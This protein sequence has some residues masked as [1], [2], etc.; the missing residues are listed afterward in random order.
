MSVVVA[1]LVLVWPAVCPCLGGGGEEMF[2]PKP[3][4]PLSGPAHSQRR[5]ILLSVLC[6]DLS[7]QGKNLMHFS[8][9][10]RHVKMRRFSDVP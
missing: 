10:D 9:A 5:I 4:P 2:Y 8:R 7:L 3:E 6:T 1:L